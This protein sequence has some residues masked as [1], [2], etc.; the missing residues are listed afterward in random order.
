[1]KIFHRIV[2]SALLVTT[3]G[4]IAQPMGELPRVVEHQWGCC[5]LQIPDLRTLAY[6]EVIDLLGEIESGSLDERCSMEELDRINQ[7]V[8][9]L[10]SEGATDEEKGEIDS[11]IAS[12][13]QRDNDVFSGFGIEID[14][15]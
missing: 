12:L 6:D 14:I 3:P 15:C 9:L 1:M 10:A 13:F 11:S 2:Q 5:S 8:A 4:V 7:F